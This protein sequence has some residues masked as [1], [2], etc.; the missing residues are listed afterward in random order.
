MKRAVCYILIALFAVSL[1]ATDTIMMDISYYLGQYPQTEDGYWEDNY[2]S[3]SSVD[4]G[5]FSFS[6]RG[7]EDGGGGM[8]YWEGFTVCTSGDQ[9]N[10]AQEGSSDGW[11]TRQWGC[12]AGG[13]LDSSFTMV[14]GMP[15]LVG[16]WG[17][18]KERQDADYHSLRVDFN[19]EKLHQAIG[20][21]ICNHP[22]P[23]Y[24]NENGDGFAS[25][26]SSEGDFFGL[27]IH[28]LDAQGVPTGNSV[29]HELASFKNGQLVQSPDWQY[30]DLSGLGEISGL[31]FTMETTDQDLLYGANTAVYFC[32]DRLQ[33]LDTI[34]ASHPKAEAV[35]AL[36]ATVDAE[37]SIIVSWNASVPADKY[38]VYLSDSIFGETT[39]TSFVITHL[40]PYSQYTISVVSVLGSDTSDVRSID[41][42]TLDLTA[43]SAPTELRA[44]ASLNRINISWLPSTDNVAVSRYTI[45]LDSEPYRRLQTTNFTITGLEPATLY[46]IAVEAE[47]A[48]GNKSEQATLSVQTED[49]TALADFT[50]EFFFQ[51]FDLHGNYIGNQ[52]PQVSGV[53]IIKQNTNIY[54]IQ[55][56]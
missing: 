9:T 4:I 21:W 17:Y 55:V 36:N 11:I 6:H 49:D 38:I 29:R 3:N 25:A 37:D 1:F 13:G 44:E 53:Y 33:V 51:V 10:Y 15:Y 19:D 31:F 8:S 48:A 14:E 52:K 26:F 23:Y 2:T 20:V 50:D 32:L 40:K 35:N 30:V 56:N 43:P 24:G 5:L 12:M 39:D 42:V 47:D 28:G 46:T 45:Y 16:Y 18:W 54:K 22:W 27:T 34:A 7:S 41:A